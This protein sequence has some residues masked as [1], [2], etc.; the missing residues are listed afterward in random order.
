MIMDAGTLMEILKWSAGL[1]LGVLGL[2]LGKKQGRDEAKREVTVKSP[3]PEI[4]VRPAE[5][6]A[7]RA[8]VARLERRIDQL[9]D[10]QAK[11]YT[12]LIEGAAERE[13]R[14]VNELGG[15]IDTT[16]GETHRRIDQLLRDL[17]KKGGQG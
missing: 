11:Q 8:D 3:V 14:I 6:Y 12:Q 13:R 15:K 2:V 4:T 1:I 5:Q 7:T 16:A 10:D 9:E 17:A